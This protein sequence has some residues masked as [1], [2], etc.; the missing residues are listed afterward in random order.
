MLVIRLAMASIALTFALARPVDVAAQPSPSWTPPANGMGV[1]A[2]APPAGWTPPPGS[3]GIGA[4]A[5]SPLNPSPVDLLPPPQQVAIKC[6]Q[7]VGQ[8]TREFA[9]CTGGY[10][11]LPSKAQATIDCAVS[12]QT[13]TEFAMCGAIVAGVR[14]SREQQITARCAMDSE[15]DSDSF[16]SCTGTGLLANQLTPQQQAI[17]QCGANANGSYSAFAACSATH[18]IGPR[19]S[20]EQR[21]AVECAAESGADS[22]AFAAC[23]GTQYLNIG[24]N[25]EQRVA[26]ECVGATGGQPYAAAGCIATR[27]LTRELEKCTSG[28]WGGSGGCFGDT[29]DVFGKDGWLARSFNDIAGGSH[30]VVHDPALLFGG[31]NSVFRNPGQLAGGPNSVIR[32]P[33]QLLQPVTVGRIGGHRVCVPWC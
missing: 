32:N 25:P 24:L 2:L 17:V 26:V 20:R 19:L 29:N 1:G 8:D 4:I 27:L 13:E 21:I 30:S 9:R 5:P 18:I 11:I 23:A 12:S 3:M 15:G 6:A 14:L 28:Q 33:A 16:V 22:T 31:P 10:I 7:R